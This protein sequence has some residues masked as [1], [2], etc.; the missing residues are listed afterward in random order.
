MHLNASFVDN[1]SV[2]LVTDSVQ[3]YT[4]YPL[5][6]H[7]YHPVYDKTTPTPL[8]VGADPHIPPQLR[9]DDKPQVSVTPPELPFSLSVF[10]NTSQPASLPYIFTLQ[11]EFPRRWTL[12]QIGPPRTSIEI[13]NG[14]PL[15]ITVVPAG[16]AWSNSPLAI[17]VT[18]TGLY[19]NSL[20]PGTHSFV[21]TAI[22][23]RG[24]SAFAEG[25]LNVSS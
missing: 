19:A 23:H 21:L 20:S 10:G 1:R 12:W 22:N 11:S 16:G 9:E 13:T 3:S 6:I 5:T 15:N 25:K 8:Q 18:I 7:E 2:M 4:G 14:I 17:S 24:L